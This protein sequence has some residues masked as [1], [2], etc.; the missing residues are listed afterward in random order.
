M[1]QERPDLAS[2]Q[3][4]RGKDGGETGGEKCD[5]RSESNYRSVKRAVFDSRY[6]EGG[7]NV[8]Y[9]EAGCPGGERQSQ[10]PARE[11]QG[12]ALDQNACDDLSSRRA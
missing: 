11:G 8:I 2:G 5:R 7:G 4:Q 1:A 3:A 9:D 12:Y 6:E 10:N